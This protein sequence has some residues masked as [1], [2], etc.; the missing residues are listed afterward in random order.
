MPAQG[1]PDEELEV[2]GLKVL[3]CSHVRRLLREGI[4]FAD[5]LPAEDNS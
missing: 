2:P 3:V 1:E 4:S 5:V